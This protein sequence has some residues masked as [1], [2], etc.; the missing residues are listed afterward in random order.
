MLKKYA[1]NEIKFVVLIETIQTT[2]SHHLYTGENDEPNFLDDASDWTIESK[3][4]HMLR[5]DSELW[6]DYWSII[7]PKIQD[8]HVLY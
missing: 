4:N 1:P 6:R 5:E 8:S 3:A 2:L 7:M